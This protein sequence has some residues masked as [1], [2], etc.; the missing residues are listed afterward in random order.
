MLSGQFSSNHARVAVLNASDIIILPHCKFLAPA[1][2]NLTQAMA[3]IVLS[4]PGIFAVLHPLRQRP[5]GANQ[6]LKPNFSIVVPVNGCDCSASK[7]P[8]E[9]RPPLKIVGVSNGLARSLRFES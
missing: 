8:L 3:E 5:S 2:Y 4:E 6:R 9:P 7:R 1:F